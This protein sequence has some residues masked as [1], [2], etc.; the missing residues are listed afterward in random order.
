MSYKGETEPLIAYTP[1]PQR[2]PGWSRLQF[3]LAVA[4]CFV[5]LTGSWHAYSWFSVYRFYF[6]SNDRGL[7][8]TL[9][10]GPIVMARG[11]VTT[12]LGVCNLGGG[13]AVTHRRHGKFSRVNHKG[14]VN[15]EGTSK[16]K[17]SVAVDVRA[18]SKAL[19]NAFEISL[20]GNELVIDV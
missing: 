9:R 4:F 5:L 20:H 14:H 12:G 18:S 17:I 2:R 3:C 8:G 6:R 13:F 1:V 11:S 10:T 15:I 16:N 19:A 7:T